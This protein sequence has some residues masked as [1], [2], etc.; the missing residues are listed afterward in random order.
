MANA[1]H[2]NLLK[3]NVNTWNKWQKENP[4]TIPDLRNADLSDTYLSGADLTRADLTGANLCRTVLSWAHLSYAD[5]TDTNLTGTDFSGADL[6]GVD[7]SKTD[8]TQAII[9]SANLGSSDL[10]GTIF[11][12]EGKPNGPVSFLDLASCIGID[13]AKFSDTDFLIT[14]LEK[15]F[16]Y[17]HA[18]DPEEVKRWPEFIDRVIDKIRL[19]HA[20][21]A[22]KEPPKQVIK[23]VG[24]INAEIMEYLK[25]HPNTMRDI[26]PH[27]FEKIVTKILTSFGWQVQLTP[28]ANEGSYDIFA[29]SKKI[30]AIKTSWIIECKKNSLERKVTADVVRSIY[31][32]DSLCNTETTMFATTSNI[33]DGA[34]EI[35]PSIYHLCPE[36]F[37]EIIQ[38]INNNR[39]KRRT[40]NKR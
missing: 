2:V 4:D 12:S 11:P 5:L 38:W 3:R 35:K 33:T 15:A 30:A 20:L 10:R 18:P 21:Y 32:I 25:T 23:V 28:T 9:C 29:I 36:D 27:Q 39:P 37:E 8:L 22:D 24:A 6:F 13:T 19:L 16:S 34:K 31:G 40:I 7:L 14:Y 17:V 1:E 26:R